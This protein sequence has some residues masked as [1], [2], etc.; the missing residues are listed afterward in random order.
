MRK[1]S[2]I[3]RISFSQFLELSRFFS[4]LSTI[5]SKASLIME[6]RRVSEINKRDLWLLPVRENCHVGLHWQ[7][8]NAHD[9]GDK[10]NCASCV[11]WRLRVHSYWA[12]SSARSW[13]F[14]M[15]SKAPIP[16]I[17][18][19]NFIRSRWESVDRVPTSFYRMSRR[20]CPS[21]CQIRI[22][23]KWMREYRLIRRHYG[24]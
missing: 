8:N 4:I 10:D 1:D 19:E 9:K 14:Q 2:A 16:R 15:R 12:L 11:F 21:R 23:E 17:S 7:W 24:M 5:L 13:P 18:S 6:N 20:P 22:A 3:F